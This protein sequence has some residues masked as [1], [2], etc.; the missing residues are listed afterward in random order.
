[1]KTFDDIKAEHPEIVT[2]N[3][4]THVGGNDC[5][6]RWYNMY[7]GALTDTHMQLM[8]DGTYVIIGSRLTKE[9][10][11]QIQYNRTLRSAPGTML[12]HCWYEVMAANKLEY[13][14]T[15]HNGQFAIALEVPPSADTGE[16]SIPMTTSVCYNMVG[17]ACDGAK[18]AGC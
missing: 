6:T 4:N 3:T 17:N 10:W 14:Y 13:A 1:M 8:D 7:W 18:C 16:R 11:N 15:T 5:I 12:P 2:Q 9:L